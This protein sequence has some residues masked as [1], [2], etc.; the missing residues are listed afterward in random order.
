MISDR[1]HGAREKWTA[2]SILIPSVCSIR[3]APH[4]K[5]IY[6]AIARTVDRDGRSPKVVKRVVVK[7]DSSAPSCAG[8]TIDA[9]P[10][11]V[12]RV[13]IHRPAPA[14]ASSRFGSVI[15]RNHSNH[16]VVTNYKSRTSIRISHASD[17]GVIPFKRVVLYKQKLG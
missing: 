7:Q 13:N 15:E 1:A 12:V 5:R 4:S 9:K 14:L 16:A 8:E 6:H 10:V 17:S 3:A 2:W 11:N